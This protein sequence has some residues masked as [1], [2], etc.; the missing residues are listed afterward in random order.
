MSNKAHDKD[1]AAFPGLS[2]K[3]VE[4]TDGKT[5]SIPENLDG[6]KPNGDKV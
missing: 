6:T 3:K 4:S 5:A 2:T 1:N